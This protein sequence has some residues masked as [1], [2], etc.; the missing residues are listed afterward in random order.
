LSTG[1]DVDSDGA[2]DTYYQSP[3][4]W[5]NEERAL[6]TISLKPVKFSET[7]E[8][9]VYFDVNTDGSVDSGDSLI[10]GKAL[11]LTITDPE[12]GAV[13]VYR[14]YSYRNTSS[15]E[16][17][18]GYFRFPNV[19]WADNSYTGPQSSASAVLTVEGET[20]VLP[21]AAVTITAGGNNY[22]EVLYQHQP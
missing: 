18:D 13:T 4:I 16:A 12:F 5:E 2:D 7:L 6:D 21:S 8:G 20:T 1:A 11:L 17:E 14:T 22:A 19:T 3:A 9:T 15:S 10:N